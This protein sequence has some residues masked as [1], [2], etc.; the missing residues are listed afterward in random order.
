M[1]WLHNLVLCGMRHPDTTMMLLLGFTMMEIQVI[2]VY[3]LFPTLT[4]F[5]TECSFSVK[6]SHGYLLYF[7]VLFDLEYFGGP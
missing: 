7:P 3:V 5:V 2:F 6:D 4:N 1:V